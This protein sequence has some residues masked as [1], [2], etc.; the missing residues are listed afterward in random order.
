MVLWM[1][2]AMGEP[3]A[4]EG[5]PKVTGG[6][7]GCSKKVAGEAEFTDKK[8]I[9]TVLIMKNDNCTLPGCSFLLPL[10]EDWCGAPSRHTHSQDQ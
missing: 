7:G 9:Q 8:N 3:S 1:I 5:Q 2:E 4:A 6:W 10:R